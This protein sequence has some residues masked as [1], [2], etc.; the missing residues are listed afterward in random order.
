MVL[1]LN[2]SDLFKQK[3][4]KFPITVCPDLQGFDGDVNSFR[5]TAKFIEEE[6]MIRNRSPMKT[7]YPHV[8]CATNRK[9]VAVVFNGVK[10]TIL[11]KSLEQAGLVLT[12]Y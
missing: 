5:Q 12:D 1:F 4:R 6:F 7:V 11:K 10:D 8:T 3:I 2:K 9:N